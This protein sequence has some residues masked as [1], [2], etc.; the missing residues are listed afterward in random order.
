M[1]TKKASLP[2]ALQNR[3]SPLVNW[4]QPYI[5]YAGNAKTGALYLSYVRAFLTRWCEN[6]LQPPLENVTADSLNAFLLTPPRKTAY[7]T[8]F[9]AAWNKFSDFMRA[10]YGCDVAAFQ[11]FLP[12]SVTSFPADSFLLLSQFVRI[13]LLYGAVWNE[14]ERQP[15]GE[16]VFHRSGYP[17]YVVP[18][19][20]VAMT[21]EPLLQW[22]YGGNS[23]IWHTPCPLVPAEA[24]SAQIMTKQVLHKLLA[25]YTRKMHADMP[26]VTKQYDLTVLAQ[27]AIM[28][29]GSED[30]FSTF[31]EILTEQMEQ[32]ETFWKEG[33]KSNPAREQEAKE[34]YLLQEAEA[35]A[36]VLEEATDE[37]KAAF[38]LPPS[39]LAE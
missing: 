25:A 37:E 12:E 3:G 10:T 28:A 29:A 26:A 13:K 2:L 17:Q 39:D 1:R 30:R 21:L 35:E 14:F 8:T 20:V 38:G 9:Q 34:A 16:V 15:T 22:G 11:V 33:V 32:R 6:P 31:L 7:R 24:H 27:F 4:E 36:G 5:D 18:A 19:G 23:N